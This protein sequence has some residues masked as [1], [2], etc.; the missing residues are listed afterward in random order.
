MTTNSIWLE[1]SLGFPNYKL[2]SDNSGVGSPKL[3][4]DSA[5]EKTEWIKTRDL[6][7]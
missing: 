2:L 1:T 4:F 3:S 7:V 5:S 6:R